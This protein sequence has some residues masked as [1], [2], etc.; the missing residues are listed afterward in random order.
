M[1]IPLRIVEDMGELL[2]K[3]DAAIIIGTGGR[4]QLALVCP[5]CGKVSASREKHVYDKETRSYTPSIV[6]NK[7]Y[8]GCGWHGWL[9]NGIFTEC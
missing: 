6:H 3:G 4:T 5:G 1:E 8:G 9:T 2:N 7:K